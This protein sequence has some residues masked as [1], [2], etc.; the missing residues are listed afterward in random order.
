MQAALDLKRESTV[1]RRQE[2]GPAGEESETC[3]QKQVEGVLFADCL[4]LLGVF[5]G[6]PFSPPI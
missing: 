4:K 5:T 6:S 1:C 3:G 2:P